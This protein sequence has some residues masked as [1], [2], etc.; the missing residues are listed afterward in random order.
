[1]LGSFSHMLQ[2]RGS[3]GKLFMVHLCRDESWDTGCWWGGGHSDFKCVFVE[4]RLPG[5]MST[6][7]VCA[8]IAC[9]P[10]GVHGII[11]MTGKIVR[12]NRYVCIYR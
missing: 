6:A 4:P 3:V 8:A 7:G 5:L 10:K 2:R 9:P 11:G 1:M 12:K